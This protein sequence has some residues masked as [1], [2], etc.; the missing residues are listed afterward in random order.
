MKISIMAFMAKR[1]ILFQLLNYAK[2]YSLGFNQFDQ[3]LLFF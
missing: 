1:Q 3:I 2:E